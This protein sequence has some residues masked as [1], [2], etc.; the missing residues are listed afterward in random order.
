MIRAAFSFFILALVAYALGAYGIAGLSVEI[1]KIFLAVFLGLA[2]VTFFASFITR[3][4]T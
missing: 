1:G 3:K 2:I 4:S